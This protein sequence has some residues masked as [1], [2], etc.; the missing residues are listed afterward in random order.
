[1]KLRGDHPGHAW[2]HS[3][4][5][6]QAAVVP[7]VR[8]PSRVDSLDLIQHA[9]TH[10]DARRS[11][12]VHPPRLTAPAPAAPIAQ[13]CERATEPPGSEVRLRQAPPVPLT[14][15]ACQATPYAESPGARRDDRAVD[16]DSRL[17]TCGT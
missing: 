16:H 15:R 13:A 9:I 2:R 8:R 1:M 10:R 17:Y 5:L 11:E 7:H 4:C 6:S 14:G 3:R 12:L